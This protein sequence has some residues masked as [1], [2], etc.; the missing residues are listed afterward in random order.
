M[1][2][3]EGNCEGS[4]IPKAVGESSVGASVKS[5]GKD[6]NPKTN[7]YVPIE[8]LVTLNQACVDVPSCSGSDLAETVAENENDEILSYMANMFDEG[9]AVEATE[10]RLTQAQE[11][12]SL[13]YAM[14]HMTHLYSNEVPVGFVGDYTRRDH[15]WAEWRDM[16]RNDD[17]RDKVGV[18]SVKDKMQ[19]ARLRWFGHVQRRDIDTVRKCERL[20]MD[21]FMSGRGKTKKYWGEV[22]RRDMTQVPI[23]EVDESSGQAYIREGNKSAHVLAKLGSKLLTC[24]QLCNTLVPPE[25]ARNT[26]KEGSGRQSS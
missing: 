19:E 25:A 13:Y 22:I 9:P 24:N 8:G 6:L 7:E 16:I 26:I 10:V 21:G 14:H 2:A 15:T 20:A 5:L 11:I 12:A 23:E 3:E 4:G 18:T 1:A 17:I